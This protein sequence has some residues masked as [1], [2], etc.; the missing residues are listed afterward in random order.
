MGCCT[1]SPSQVST[2]K[3]AS[4][5]TKGASNRSPSL[6]GTNELFHELGLVTSAKSTTLHENGTARLRVKQ[7]QP[8]EIFG[9][10]NKLRSDASNTSE[11]QVNDKQ[12]DDLITFNMY[13]EEK[14]MYMYIL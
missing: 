11:Q 4:S 1:S 5:E 6:L 10:L 7:T 12:R 13:P 8:V 2:Q 3:L 14:D 9:T